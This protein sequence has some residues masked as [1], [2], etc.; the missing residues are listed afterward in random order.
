MSPRNHRAPPLPPSSSKPTTPPPPSAYAAPPWSL[1]SNSGSARMRHRH[2]AAADGR[3]AHVSGHLKLSLAEPRAPTSAAGAGG[4]RSPP[5]PT[6]TS[7]INRPRPSPHIA[8]AYFKCFRYIFQMFHMNVA[9]VEACCNISVPNVS[10][11]FFRRMLQVCLFRCC[12]CF[13]HILQ[14]FYLDVVYVLQ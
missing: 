10:S 12:L 7:R 2:G 11:V 14:V 5:A 8:N 9:Y 13:I 3:W 4:A 6:S 1:F